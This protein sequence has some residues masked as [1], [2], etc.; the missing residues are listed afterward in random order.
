MEIQPNTREND[1]DDD[2]FRIGQAHSVNIEHRVPH[3]LD[4]IFQF[5]YGCTK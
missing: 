3:Q 2:D 5:I 1:D 4:A